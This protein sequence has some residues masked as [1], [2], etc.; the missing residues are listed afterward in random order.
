MAD[1]T[2]LNGN[3]VSIYIRT[4]TGPDVYKLLVCATEASLTTSKDVIETITKCSRIV[5][6][7]TFKWDMSF[8][9][10]IDTAPDTGEYSLDDLW[11]A[12]AA[13]T[14]VHAGFQNATPNWG[15]HGDGYVTKIDVSAP[16]DGLVTYTVTIAGNG[17]LTQL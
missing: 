12:Y 15:F 2:T 16:V 14:A 7:G 8:S 1:P 6:S 9:G 11:T 17:G 3:D 4:S 5:K 10:V 13:G